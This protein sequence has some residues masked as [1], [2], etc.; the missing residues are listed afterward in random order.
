MPR[1]T[2]GQIW[3][4]TKKQKKTITR[5]RK[6]IKITIIKTE[7]YIKTKDGIKTFYRWRVEQYIGYHL[8]SNMI[9]HHINFNHEDNDLS[10]LFITTRAFHS[11]IHK[12]KFK[13]LVSNLSLYIKE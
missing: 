12:C 11:W 3:T 10:N 5:N 1:H 8:T 2:I 6:K 13:N 7:T 4:K 9:V